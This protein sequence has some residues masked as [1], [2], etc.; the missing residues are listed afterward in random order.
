MADL[1]LVFL[2]QCHETDAGSTRSSRN[3][4]QEPAAHARTEPLGHIA[5]KNH[6]Q[7]PASPFAPPPAFGIPP[8]P[9]IGGTKEHS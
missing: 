4:E 5:S 1:L 9:P 8:A 3:L 6:T 7:E 2:K